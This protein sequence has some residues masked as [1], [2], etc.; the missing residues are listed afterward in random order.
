MSIFPLCSA[1]GSTIF[2]FALSGNGKEFFNPIPDPDADPD[3]HRNLITSTLGLVFS[4]K[5][6]ATPACNFL[7][8]PADELAGKVKGPYTSGA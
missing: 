3:H 5:I 4:L 8:N 1:G 2:G 6:S 7:C